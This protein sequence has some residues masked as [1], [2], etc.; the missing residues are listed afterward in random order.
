[1]FDEYYDDVDEGGEFIIPG[2]EKDRSKSRY[3]N[4]DD[5]DKIRHRS[6]LVSRVS[7]YPLNMY[8]AGTDSS[9]AERGFSAGAVD[10]RLAVL[11]DTGP[12]F[13]NVL[14]NVHR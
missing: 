14:E 3:H 12:S 5:E 8:H 13:K 10:T 1:M 4:Q 6:A 11:K 2:K 7:L 9:S